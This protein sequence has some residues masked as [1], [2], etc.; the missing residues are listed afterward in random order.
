MKAGKSLTALSIIVLLL[1]LAAQPA[2]AAEYRVSSDSACTL[3]DA[4]KSANK[5]RAVGGCEAGGDVDVIRISGDI[6]LDS[7]LPTIRSSMTIISDDASVK[8]TIDGNFSGRIF[9]IKGG[10][11][12][13]RSLQLING[14]NYG[15]RG[16]AVRILRGHVA[17]ID[18]RME[19]NWAEK[20]G[21]ALRAG[22][23]GSVTCNQCAFV[24]NE[25]ADGGAIWAGD[26]SNITL[27]DSMVYNNTALRGGGM[28]INQGRAALY[29]TSFSNNHAP[30]GAD[31]F[32]IDAEVIHQP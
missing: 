32:T 1:S 26:Y 15:Q 24:D 18:M 23:K 2:L 22:N 27:I 19:H 6:T 12:T 8:R 3:A 25:S 9:N 16:G 17:L 21:G 5:N 30:E 20:G 31:L 4:I 7:Q 13:I 28:F 11:V 10:N 14:R 29:G